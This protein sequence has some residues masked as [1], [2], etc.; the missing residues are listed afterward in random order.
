MRIYWLVFGMLLLGFL[1]TASAQQSPVTLEQSNRNTITPVPGR[2]NVIIQETPAP[3]I[4]PPEA[5]APPP[6]T[7]Q[8]VHGKQAVIRHR[9]DKS[10]S[11]VQE[12]DEIEGWKILAITDRLVTIEKRISAKRAIR[13][14]I[15]VEGVF[16]SQ[17][18]GKP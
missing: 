18:G 2:M 3:D 13:A 14:M 16:S 6:V 1:A 9:K 10:E 12:G 5:M 11:M 8:Q 17:D 7:I 4:V 15:P